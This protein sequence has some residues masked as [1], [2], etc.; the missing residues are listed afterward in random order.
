MNYRTPDQEL[1][2]I[3]VFF[4]VWRKYLEGAQHKITV[5]TDHHNL[6]S[7]L[8]AKTLSRRQAHW[9]EFL[10]AFNFEIQYVPG[11]RNPADGP[12]RRKDYNGLD[13]PY[14]MVPFFRLAITQ[15]A[16]G[17]EAFEEVA[18]DMDNLEQEDDETN[19]LS[20]TILEAIKQALQ[21][22][23]AALSAQGADYKWI[24]GLLYFQGL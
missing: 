7:F 10:S 13:R 6:K 24:E 18:R 16:E 11:K 3:V 8:T 12:S 5:L 15:V 22:D 20:E 2:A 23:P 1:L 9:A 17:R 4:Q 14:T 19:Q 21:Q